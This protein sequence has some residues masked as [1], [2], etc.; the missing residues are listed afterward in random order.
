MER[1]EPKAGNENQVLLN[2]LY[3]PF[4]FSEGLCCVRF[5]FE[6]GLARGYKDVGPAPDTWPFGSKVEFFAD[7]MLSD[8]GV[9][10]E[11]RAEALAKYLGT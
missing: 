6:S 1:I 5:T 2:A 8:M 10:E 7:R 11:Q 3:G 9:T 4:E